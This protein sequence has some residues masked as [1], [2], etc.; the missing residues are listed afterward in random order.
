M[1]SW[2]RPKTVGIALMFLAV[3]IGIGI[4]AVPPAEAQQQASAVFSVITGNVRFMNKGDAAWQKA[5]VGMRVTE[6][7]DVVAEP[8]SGAE[9]RLH[10][11]IGRY[12]LGENT[13]LVARPGRILAITG[14][15]ENRD[16]N[17]SA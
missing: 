2:K 3:A 12:V 13:L 8:G 15:V 5:Q 17:F 6:G 9:L 16:G 11:G 10:A 4:L 7:A 14:K 1:H